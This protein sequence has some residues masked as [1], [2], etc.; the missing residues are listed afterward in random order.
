MQ[1]VLNEAD[2]ALYHVKH[3][4]KDGCCFYQSGMTA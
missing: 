3:N 2:I 4:G 1:D